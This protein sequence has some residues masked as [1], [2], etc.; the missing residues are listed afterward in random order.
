[1][2]WSNQVALVTGGSRGIGRAVALLLAQRGAAVCVGY[3]GRADAAEAV[4][5]E[6]CKSGGRAIA[7]GADVSDSAAVAS[8]VSRAAGALGPVTI[9][10]NSA[11][12]HYGAT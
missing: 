5:D 9:L 4:V 10:V 7:A 12:S 1:M 3:A 2:A 6:I 11:G 8:M